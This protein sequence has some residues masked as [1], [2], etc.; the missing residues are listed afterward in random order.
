LFSENIYGKSF[1]RVT[2]ECINDRHE[3]GFDHSIIGKI[4]KLRMI[5]M[6]PVIRQISTNLIAGK[7]NL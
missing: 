2:A 5:D 1:S 3:K 7:N 6:Q 4:F